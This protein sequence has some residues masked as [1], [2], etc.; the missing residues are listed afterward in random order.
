MGV[1]PAG[2]LVPA[3]GGTGRGRAAWIR[4]RRRGAACVRC[5]Q[6]GPVMCNLRTISTIYF[7]YLI[8][9][10][11]FYR[12]I[13]EKPINTR[14]LHYINCI[15]LCM[16]VLVVFVLLLSDY[17]GGCCMLFCCIFCVYGYIL[18]YLPRYFF[19]RALGFR[20]AVGADL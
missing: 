11:F 3:K 5:I 1:I 15:E 20:S 7:I 13:P 8:N 14:F 18:L 9:I 10:S 6:C 4:S 19:R 2:P 12:W 16:P 17:L